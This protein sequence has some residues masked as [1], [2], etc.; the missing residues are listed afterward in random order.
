MIVE[1]PTNVIS[2][3]P[4]CPGGISLIC[5]LRLKYGAEMS[6]LKLILIKSTKAFQKSY[7]CTK[8]VSDNLQDVIKLTL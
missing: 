3:I 7:T 8:I 2:A 1:R 5:A 6:E 4:M